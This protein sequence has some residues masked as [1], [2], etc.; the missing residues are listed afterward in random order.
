MFRGVPW[1]RQ[2]DALIQQRV[3]TKEWM[4]SWSRR[5]PGCAVED[6]WLGVAGRINPAVTAA[7][8]ASIQIYLSIPAQE[9]ISHVMLVDLNGWRKT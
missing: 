4:W 8:R 3:S 6:M 2:S 9:S 1:P 5:Q 7:V